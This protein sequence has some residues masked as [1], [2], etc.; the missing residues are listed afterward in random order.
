M[1]DTRQ[2]KATE[3]LKEDIELEIR[4]LRLDLKITDIEPITRA[5][6]VT[7]SYPDFLVARK[8]AEKK[9]WTITRAV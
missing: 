7:G 8:I 5:V 2:H 6:A 3:R 9:G 1:Q 4:L